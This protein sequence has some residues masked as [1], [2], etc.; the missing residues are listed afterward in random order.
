MYLT[1]EII[2]SEG[3]AFLVRTPEDNDKICAINFHDVSGC[4]V[5]QSELKSSSCRCGVNQKENAVLSCKPTPFYSTRCKIDALNNLD[6]A[7]QCANVKILV[8]VSHQ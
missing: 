5:S 8:D 3:T 6:L 2:A 1:P 4:S 7:P